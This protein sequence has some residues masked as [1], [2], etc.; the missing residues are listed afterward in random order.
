M[1]VS[2][3]NRFLKNSITQLDQLETTII[4]YKRTNQIDAD[5]NIPCIL[6][7]NAV[8]LNSH[9]TFD[10]NKKVH[11]LT[12]DI[13]LDKEEFERLNLVFKNDEYLIKKL[14]NQTVSRAFVYYFKPINPLYK[15]FTVFI[16][17]SNSGK[18]KIEE[19]DLFYRIQ[20][21]ISKFNFNVI[22][23]ASDGD[24]TY[25]IL[26]QKN[27]NEWDEDS[28]P[29]LDVYQTLYSN[30]PLHILKRGRYR[31]LSHNIVLLH[32]YDTLFNTEMIQEISNLPSIVLVV[33]LR[34]ATLY[35]LRPPL[36]VSEYTPFGPFMI[37]NRKLTHFRF[38]LF[39]Y[40]HI[41]III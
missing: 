37:V 25:K 10:D 4:N 13:Q 22:S 36:D 27:I 38:K 31:L 29:I 20:D 19:I 39:F 12:H 11:G 40:R 34:G 5:I 14:K 33:I 17:G 15:C 18:A 9:I 24:S 23:Y 2:T 3:L 32:N 16:K 6:A 1:V 26:A 41:I 7:V 35:E 28:R 21:T 30:D 8:S